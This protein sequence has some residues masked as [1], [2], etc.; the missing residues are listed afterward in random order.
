MFAK[1]IDYFIPDEY[2]GDDETLRK[3]RLA[4]GVYI[5]VALFTF[6][7]S[8]ISFFI[9]FSG[10]LLSQVPLFIIS[11]IC[12]T[13]FRNAV[14]QIKIAFLF[15]TSAIILISTVIYY[16]EG[17]NSFI[18]PWLATTPIVALLVSGKLMGMYTLFG[19]LTMLVMFYYFERIEFSPPEGSLNEPPLFFVLST[20]VGLILIFYVIA[21]VFENG[22]I[23]AM[24]LLTNKNNELS[25]QKKITEAQ[26]E[27]LKQ[28]DAEKSRFFANISHEFRTPLT[29]TIAPLENLSKPKYGTLTTEGKAQ[30]D[31]A[32][33]NAKR[34]MR[35]VTQLM[36]LAR[37]EANL[38]RL[39]PE[40]APLNQY[41]RHISS[42][43]VG[44]AE[45]YNINFSINIPSDVIIAQFDPEQFEK[46]ISNLLSNA[47]KFTPEGGDVSVTLEKNE[48]EAIIRITDTGK[49]I[50]PDHLPRL[51]DRF[52]QAEKSEMQPGTGIGLALVKEITEQHGGRVD[53]TSKSGRGTE[54]SIIL[55]LE[56]VD[57]SAVVELNLSGEE[58]IE[59][60]LLP[61]KA[62]SLDEDADEEADEEL[63]TILV[64]DDNKDI[65]TYLENQ[66]SDEYRVIT[67][68]SGNKALKKTLKFLPDLI[69]SDVMMP[70]G[71][72]FTLLKNLRSNS[73]TNFLPVILLTARAEA[74]DKLEG[75][76]IGADDYL[77]KPFSMEEVSLRV[78]N[79]IER[80]KRLQKHY[81]NQNSSTNSTGVTM[82]PDVIEAASTDDL[83][84]EK[85]RQVIQQ[86]MHEEFFSVEDL[87]EK[88]YQSRIQLFRRLRDLTDESPSA[89]IRR[90]RLE[91]GMN[92]LK[93][94]A[95][96]VSEIAYSTGFKSVAQFSSS[97]S[98][99]FRKPPTHFMGHSA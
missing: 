39:K 46:V 59:E 89:L 58:G 62:F 61:E 18:L 43:F 1:L 27:K 73:E 25:E 29:L 79:L 97:F 31:M 54:F 78:Y 60:A 16:T 80:Q 41:I 24:R 72:G 20:F 42:R 19:Q 40:N 4:V 5:V 71:D 74:E 96:T 65:R 26:A 17:F 56:N 95:G 7:Y 75:L 51:F 86:H 63:K 49:G 9:D 57:V 23:N 14:S 32:T 47:F 77:T 90:M 98:K 53:V 93:Q 22:R 38:F 67:A 48:K 99:H 55:P 36:D 76:G 37:F 83:Y 3:S 15:F 91:R 33:R 2:R 92:L 66:F 45:R 87:A 81:A 94:K 68:R 52:Y 11:L 28:L 88:M 82:S 44:A 35:L 6:S 84:L 70:D 34:L 12:L 13:L 10:G 30:V 50:D 69:I 8:A 21:I 64:V 85:V